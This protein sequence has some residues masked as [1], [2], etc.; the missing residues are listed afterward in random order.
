MLEY[1]PEAV[2]ARMTGS[3]DNLSPL[4]RCFQEAFEIS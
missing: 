1:A 4:W 3:S 2:K